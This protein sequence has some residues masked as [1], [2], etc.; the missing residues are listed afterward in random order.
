[1]TIR[2]SSLESG[3]GVVSRAA[4]ERSRAPIER[5]TAWGVLFGS[6]LGAVVTFHGG[7]WAALLAEPSPGR[8]VAGILLQLVLTWLQWA[9]YRVPVIAY[10]ARALDALTTTIGYGPL[11]HGIVSGWLVAGGASAAPLLPGLGPWSAAASSTWVL[12]Y[13][14]ALVPAWYPESR[15]VRD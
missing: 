14:L 13:L 12:L 15:L 9:Y 5:W 10:P 2:R 6:A 1:M 8:I 7:S 11:L 3:S 4:L